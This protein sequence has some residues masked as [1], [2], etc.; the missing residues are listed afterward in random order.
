MVG[1]M[2]RLLALSLG[3]H[4][5]EAGILM[6]GTMLR[7]VVATTVN[8]SKAGS[9]LSVSL[10]ATIVNLTTTTLNMVSTVP[11]WWHSLYKASYH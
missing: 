10:K 7:V 3:A 6:I 11:T 8:C 1:T 9:S 4:R 2:L 5:H